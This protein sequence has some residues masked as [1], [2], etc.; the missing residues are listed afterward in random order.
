MNLFFKM[1]ISLVLILSLALSIFSCSCAPSDSEGSSDGADNGDENGPNDDNP[2]TDDP[3]GDPD[4]PTPD[5]PTPDDPTPDDEPTCTD[6]IDADD[7][8]VCDNE[9]CGTLFCDSHIDNDRDGICDVPGC[10]EAVEIPCDHNI[11]TTTFEGDCTNDGYTVD[12]CT[13]CDYESIYDI[14][15]ATGHTGNTHC[16]VCGEAI[17]P[18]DDF[19]N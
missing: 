16:T 6:H 10:T 18:E 17:L 1:L 8:G 12:E 5:D 9:G 13:L 11:I 15:F 7:D 14:V 2:G 3:N 19:T 4:D